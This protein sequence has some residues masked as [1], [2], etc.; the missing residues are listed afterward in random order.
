VTQKK[1]LP[2]LTPGDEGGVVPVRLQGGGKDLP[3]PYQGSGGRQGS[4]KPV[5]PMQRSVLSMS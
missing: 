1:S 2:T 5:L 3:V 4:R